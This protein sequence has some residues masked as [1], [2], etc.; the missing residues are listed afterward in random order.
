MQFPARRYLTLEPTRLDKLNLREMHARRIYLV[1][2]TSGI[3]ST[4]KCSRTVRIEPVYSVS[5]G[6]VKNQCVRRS[7]DGDDAVQLQATPVLKN[8]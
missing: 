2:E 8:V 7:L 1:K 6:E 5:H 4:L 3:S